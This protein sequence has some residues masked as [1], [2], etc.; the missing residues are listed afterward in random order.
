MAQAKNSSI[1]LNPEDFESLTQLRNMLDQQSEQAI[2]DN[3]TYI[4]GVL[5]EIVVFVDDKLTRA[6]RFSRRMQ[7]AEKRRKV[8]A[9]REAARTGT[10]GTQTNANASQT[11]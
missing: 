11:R 5:T 6:T 9:Q 1:P 8:R 3:K 4:A 10:K 2:T 7:N